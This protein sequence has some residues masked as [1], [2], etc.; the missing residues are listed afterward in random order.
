MVL[1]T[2]F[3]HHPTLVDIGISN[4][5]EGRNRGKKKGKERNVSHLFLLP[6]PSESTYDLNVEL[7]WRSAC[8]FLLLDFKI[9]TQK[10]HRGQDHNNFLL[11]L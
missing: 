4:G 8:M 10:H 11:L 2:L 9:H 1:Y 3:D 6:L 7:G 5:R